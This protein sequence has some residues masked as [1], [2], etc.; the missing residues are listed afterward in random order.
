MKVF[1]LEPKLRTLTFS[2]H[3]CLRLVYEV[4]FP[5]DVCAQARERCPSSSCVVRARLQRYVCVSC[6][7][8]KPFQFFLFFQQMRWATDNAVFSVPPQTC[9]VGAYQDLLEIRQPS[10]TSFFGK[11]N[12][13]DIRTVA[14]VD[15]L[16]ACVTDPRPCPELCQRLA[17][18]NKS[19]MLSEV[20]ID[21]W[22]MCDLEVRPDN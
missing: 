19:K 2:S 12:T 20:N 13:P 11:C 17:R 21:M 1:S 15:I 5:G 9:P 16:V 10:R 14:I 3:Q 4:C 22:H 6:V 8:M 7:L 18:T